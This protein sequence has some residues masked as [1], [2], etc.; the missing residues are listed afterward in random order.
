MTPRT[1]TNNIPIAHIFL[2]FYNFIAIYL[3]CA[4]NFYSSFLF[5]FYSIICCSCYFANLIFYSS[6]Y[7]C[8]CTFYSALFFCWYYSFLRYFWAYSNTYSYICLYVFPCLFL[9]CKSI[10]KFYDYFVRISKI[11]W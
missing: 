1:I 7:L 9:A 2:F 4:S 3:F 8:F 11:V 6:F 10:D 5:F